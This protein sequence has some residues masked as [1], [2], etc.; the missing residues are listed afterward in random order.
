M[1][2]DNNIL[3]NDDNITIK[4]IPPPSAL[5]FSGKIKI[6]TRPRGVTIQKKPKQVKK[7]IIPFEKPSFTLFDDTEDFY[8]PLGNAL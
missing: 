5:P 6:I 3:L 8:P 4:Q 1:I 2:S 7:I